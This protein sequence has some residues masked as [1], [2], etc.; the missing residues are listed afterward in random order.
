MCDEDGFSVKINSDNPFPHF[1]HVLPT[2]NITSV[3]V[4]GGLDAR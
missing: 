2:E 4:N 3:Y 1:I